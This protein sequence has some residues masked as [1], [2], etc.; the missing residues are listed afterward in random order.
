MASSA[1]SR[2]GFTAGSR[3]CVGGGESPDVE[4]G[5]GG[6]K[7]LAMAGDAGETG[8]FQVWGGRECD[9][10]SRPPQPYLH[11]QEVVV[12][13]L[14]DYRGDI[15]AVLRGVL[16]PVVLML[17]LMLVVWGCYYLARYLDT[18]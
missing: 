17:L 10:E 7:V 15:T 13:N 1:G 4:R 8:E 18:V 12:A 3:N 14:L 16:L 5:L 9:S 2:I 6:Y 11:A